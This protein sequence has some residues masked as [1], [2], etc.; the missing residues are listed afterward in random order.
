L[1]ALSKKMTNLTSF[2][3]YGMRYISK[4][5]LFFIA[6]CFPLLE[7]LYLSCFHNGHT[8]WLEWGDHHDQLL[9]LPK[10]REIY[11][12]GTHLKHQYIVDLCKTCELLREISV[13][14]WFY[15]S[16]YFGHAKQK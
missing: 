7:E 1:R 3:C 5:D 16:I 14:P 10:L 9:E 4:K 6:D 8:S 11:L 15:S 13:I 2:T 12:S